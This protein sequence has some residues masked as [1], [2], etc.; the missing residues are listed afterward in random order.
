MA[1]IA[2][3]LDLNSEESATERRGRAGNMEDEKIVGLFWQRSEEAIVETQA[4]YGKLCHSVAY[5]VLKNNEDSEECVN[6]T[7]VR[8]WNSIPSDQP[9]HLGA[10]VS[11][12]TRHLAID[13]YRMNT[14]AKRSA[15]TVSIFDELSE[16]LPDVAGDGMA[17][18][19]VIRDTLNRFITSLTPENRM[20]FM[21][22]Y[23]YCDSIRSIASM[24]HMTEMGVKK[25]LA[26]MRE[27]L[28]DVL[29]KEGIEA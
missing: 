15:A 23:W 16:A 24:M 14:A 26:R 7:Y 21:R 9:E 3:V 8:T 4:K 18:R 6:D 1:S 27:K 11:K 13:K 5:G 17:D 20:I 25:R 29:G 28:K 12:I 19:M 10:Y 2:K 22:R